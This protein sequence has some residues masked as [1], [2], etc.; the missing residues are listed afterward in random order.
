LTHGDFAL[1][2]LDDRTAAQDR[3]N[4]GASEG[5]IAMVEE[6]EQD[7]ERGANMRVDVM[8]GKAETAWLQACW[9]A[10]TFAA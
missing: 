9:Q 7:P 2:S 8:L 3:G 10:A 1:S 4:Q 5:E 6:S